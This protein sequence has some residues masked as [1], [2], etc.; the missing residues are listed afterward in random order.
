MKYVKTLLA[1][2]LL[3]VTFLAFSDSANAGP[4][5]EVNIGSPV[6]ARPLWSAVWVE[7]HY[8]VGAWNRLV[9]V[10]GHWRRI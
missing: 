4:R 5:F 8:R 9:W 2:I 10:P 6:V 7:G 3:T 1:A